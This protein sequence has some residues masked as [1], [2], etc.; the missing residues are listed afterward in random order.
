M[1]QLLLLAF[2]TGPEAG[3]N[4][5]TLAKGLAVYL[6]LS[7]LGGGLAFEAGKRIV[8]GAAAL[9]RV[10]AGLAVGI[11]RAWLR[12]YQFQFPRLARA[13]ISSLVHQVLPGTMTLD[14]WLQ[15]FDP[16]GWIRAELE[17]EAIAEEPE[18]P[19]GILQTPNYK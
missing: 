2:V 12:N 5:D 4:R 18:D 8:R 7:M 3:K 19:L 14:R 17:A 13:A 9:P 15:A 10:T 1:W 11:A 16:A 6:I